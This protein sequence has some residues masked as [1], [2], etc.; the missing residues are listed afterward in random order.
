MKRILKLLARLYP[1]EWRRRYGEEYEALLEQGT[2]HVRDLFDVSWGAFKMQIT[3]WSFVRIVLPCAL[4]GMLAAIAFS[5]AAPP[6]YSSQKTF[7]V[8]TTDTTANGLAS[9]GAQSAFSQEYLASVI[10]RE[11]LYPRE[12]SRMPLNDLIDKM[13]SNIHFRVTP[14]SAW[15]GFEGLRFLPIKTGTLEPVNIT[16]QFVYPDPHVAQR[17]DAAL[18][19][20]L[21]LGGG[22]LHWGYIGGPNPWGHSNE[23]LNAYLRSGASLPRKPEGLGRVQLGAVGL[24]VGLFGGLILVSAVNSRPGPT[25]AHD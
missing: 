22:P 9:E 24:L 7:P 18:V 20:Q 17:V 23:V 12:R 16:V 8:I 14:V 10:Q 4:T 5:L 13:R 1:A 6:L 11:G 2:P 25:I 3:T 15:K 19:G 21:F